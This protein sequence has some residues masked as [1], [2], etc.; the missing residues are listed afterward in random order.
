MS[1]FMSYDPEV[2]LTGFTEEQKARARCYLD[3]DFLDTIVDHGPS[4]V[5]LTVTAAGTS[6]VLKWTPPVSSYWAHDDAP[7]R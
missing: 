1:N 5:P 4:I 3:T 6:A 7:A 2:C